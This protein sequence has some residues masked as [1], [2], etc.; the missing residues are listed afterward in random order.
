M[1]TASFMS[2]DFKSYLDS[3]ASSSQGRY[4]KVADG[5]SVRFRIMSQ[6]ALDGWEGWTEENKPI[7]WPLCP[8]GEDFPANIKRR[9]NGSPDVKRFMC[10]VIWNYDLQMFQIAQFVQ[11]QILAALQSY[12]EDPDWGHPNQYDLE[13]SR[14]GTGRETKYTLIAK[15]HKKLAADIEKAYAEFFCDMS[16]LFDNGDPFTS[17][18]NETMPF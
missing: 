13:L 12:C 9:D 7:R 11:K 2:A 15:P 16:K 4:L 1:A 10:F 5:E 8:K 14:A 3:A 17:D 6:S 18:V